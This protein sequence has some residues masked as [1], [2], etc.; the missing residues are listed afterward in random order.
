MAQVE[1]RL[2]TLPPLPS[3]ELQIRGIGF[4]PHISRPRIVWAGLAGQVEQLRQLQDQVAR[5]LSDLKVHPEDKRAFGPH[6]T[7]GRIRDPR[8]VSGLVK[9]IEQGRLLQPG[10]FLVQEIILY[11]SDLT[12]KGARYTKLASFPLQGSNKEVSDG[13]GSE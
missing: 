8:Q 11:K 1:E 2:K 7:I 4:F 3:F 10:P 12:P 13:T 9:I 6:L 5:S